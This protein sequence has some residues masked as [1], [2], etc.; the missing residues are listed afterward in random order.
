MKY[1]ISVLPNNAC[2]DLP[3][4]W[5]SGKSNI[6][7]QYVILMKLHVLNSKFHAGSNGTT[8]YAI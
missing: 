5:D 8:H 1:N 6:N 2:G 4:Y 3:K 7:F